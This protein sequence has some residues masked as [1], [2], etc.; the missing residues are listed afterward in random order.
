MQSVL[1]LVV[2]VKTV[3]LLENSFKGVIL[4]ILGTQNFI[5]SVNS[6]LEYS[7]DAA[8]LPSVTKLTSGYQDPNSDLHTDCRTVTF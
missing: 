1:V 3:N 5:L 8:A 2:F 7:K 6:W 4:R